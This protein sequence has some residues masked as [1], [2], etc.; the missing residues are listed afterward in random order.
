MPL[1]HDTA[2][3]LSTMAALINTA[4]D[5]P[6][7]L[8]TPADLDEFLA[9]ERFSGSRTH[10]AGELRAVRHLRTRLRQLWTANEE[11]LAAGVNQ[12]LRNAGARPQVVRHDEWGWHLHC[13]SPAAP[14]EERLATEAAMALAD[15]LRGGELDRLGTCAAPDCSAVILDVTRNRSKRYCD[16]G[17]CGNRQHVRSYRSRRAATQKTVRPRQ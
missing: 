4:A 1:G 14:L 12:L 16:T 5:H 6:D 2:D 15:V 11:Q 10:T 9:R 13:T 8:L 7:A 3:S 17:N